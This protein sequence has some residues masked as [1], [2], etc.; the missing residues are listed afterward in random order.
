MENT[1]VQVKGGKYFG[2]SWF[3]AYNYKLTETAIDFT[4]DE[5]SLLQGSGRIKPKNK[6][7]T[8]IKY[9]TITSVASKRKYSVPNVAVAVIGA[10]MGLMT[11][12]YIL[13]PILLLIWLG[14]TAQVKINYAGQEYVIPTEFLKDAQELESKINTA[15]LQSRS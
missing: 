9:N 5:I 1:K 10:I 8:D 15:I 2:K 11:E 4:D 14:R 12:A 3:C 7:K 13:I 6:V